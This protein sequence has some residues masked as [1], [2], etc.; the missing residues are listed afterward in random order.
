MNRKIISLFSLFFLFLPVTCQAITQISNGIHN[1]YYPSGYG[2]HIAWT[3]FSDDSNAASVLFWNGTSISTI[4]AGYGNANYPS[5]HDGNIAWCGSIEGGQSTDIFLWNGSTTERITTRG[6]QC[7]PTLYNG[8]I[9]WVGDDVAPGL[10]NEIYFWDGSST[11][12]VSNN[13]ELDDSPSLYDGT[14]AWAA[15]Y[16]SG[17][18]A[19]RSQIKFWDGS[20]TKIISPAHLDANCPSLYDGEVAY[21]ASLENV[22]DNTFINYWN[23]STTRQISPD[24]VDVGCPT[25]NNGNIAY[26]IHDTTLSRSKLMFT[27]GIRTF[28]IREG[29]YFNIHQPTL[30]HEY[31]SWSEQSGDYQ[32]IFTISITE[33]LAYAGEDRTITTNQSLNLDGS[34][35]VDLDGTITSWDWQLSHEDNPALNRTLH[36]EKVEIRD[37]QAGKYLVILTVTDNDGKQGTDSFTLRVTKGLYSFLP[38]IVNG[39]NPSIF[40]GGEF[41][42]HGNWR[43]TFSGT[44]RGTWDVYIN[45]QGVITGSGISTYGSFSIRGRVLIDGDFAATSYSTGGN[46]ALGSSYLGEIKAPGTVK[47]SWQNNSDSGHKGTFEGGLQKR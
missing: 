38:A 28:T 39:A 9:A 5:N 19:Y 2:Q 35:S 37:L 29:H 1:N 6:S 31:L 45:K 11:I 25:L 34:G 21:T 43:G 16:I 36:G 8:T 22:Y 3:Q 26:V 44:D 7:S 12:Q 42:Y 23:G 15:T 27:D 10:N 13:S 33:P 18:N 41:I 20:T 17:T 30:S 46:A 14:I 4:S 24:G 47:G 32:E 40:Q